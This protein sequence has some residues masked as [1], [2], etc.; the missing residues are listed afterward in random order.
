M[1]IIYWHLLNNT[2]YC[3]FMGEQLYLLLPAI[4][5]YKFISISL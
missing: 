4:L 3:V 1:K 5:C 2:I